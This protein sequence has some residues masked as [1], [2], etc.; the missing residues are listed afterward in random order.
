MY[1]IFE[2]ALFFLFCQQLNAESQLH[3]EIKALELCMYL[4]KYPMFHKMFY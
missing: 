1:F 3:A 4:I 2:N